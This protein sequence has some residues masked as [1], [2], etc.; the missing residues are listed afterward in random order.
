MNGIHGSD[1]LIYRGAGDVIAQRLSLSSKQ[2]HIELQRTCFSTVYGGLFNGIVGHVWYDGLD[3]V[4]TRMVSLQ[5][6][7][8]VF[9]VVA[10][11][12]VFGPVHIA[13][14]FTS[15][16]LMEERH[17]SFDDRMECVWRKLEKDFTSTF[18]AELC[19]WPCIQAVNFRWCPV[20]YQLL[21]VNCFVVLDA[22]F[23]SYVQHHDDWIASIFGGG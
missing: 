5:R 6:P 12:L 15:L 3:R 9:K 2:E 10:D 17:R 13:A 18:V 8:L 4:A 11:S 1:T 14:Y 16:T 7:R 23:M 19:V 22:A 21:V 20:Q